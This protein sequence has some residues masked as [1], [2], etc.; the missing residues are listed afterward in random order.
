MVHQLKIFTTE[1]NFYEHRAFV[2]PDSDPASS[3]NMTWT[4]ARGPG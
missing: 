3:Q 1:G 2:M 4:Q